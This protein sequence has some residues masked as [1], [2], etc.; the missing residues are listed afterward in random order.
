MIEVLISRK[1]LG[2]GRA[3]AVQMLAF[4]HN[5]FWLKSFSH[6]FN[7]ASVFAEF[8]NTVFH[9]FGSLKCL[10]N[11]FL[12]LIFHM[13]MSY[14]ICPKAKDFYPIILCCFRIEILVATPSYCVLTTMCWAS[15]SNTWHTSFLLDN[16][17]EVVNWI[18]YDEVW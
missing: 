13:L 7:L 1:I 5:F 4:S 9:S 11:Q 18:S 15:Y 3:N 14:T 8:Y 10:C 16:L 2:S 6:N 17:M 12:L